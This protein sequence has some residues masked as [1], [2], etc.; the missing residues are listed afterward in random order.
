MTAVQLLALSTP[1]V[2]GAAL[3]T[4]AYWVRTQNRAPVLSSGIA[5]S[6]AAEP[7]GQAWK[8]TDTTAPAPRAEA[9]RGSLDE[10][11]RHA[12]FEKLTSIKAMSIA[13]LAD[14]ERALADLQRF[15]ST[16]RVA[17]RTARS[18]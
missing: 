15:V 17:S 4:L 6:G 14:A 8:E 12:D 16:A 13:N 7:T 11:S 2:I 9:H 5:E 10:M 1:A 18:E 3:L